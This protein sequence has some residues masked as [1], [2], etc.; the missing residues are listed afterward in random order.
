M[1]LL[2]DA[3]SALYLGCDRETALSL[4]PKY[5]RTAAKA[6]RFAMEQAA[7]VSLRGAL[8]RVGGIQL[9]RAQIA[10]LHG[11]LADRR[12]GQRALLARSDIDM[13]AARA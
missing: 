12:E 10:G 7:P 11:T 9:N 5:F 13:P 1:T 2:L 3:P 6:I 4:G 8:L